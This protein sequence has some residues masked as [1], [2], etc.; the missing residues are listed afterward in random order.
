M[1]RTLGQQFAPYTIPEG[2]KIEISHLNDPVGHGAAL[3]MYIHALPHLFLP[4]Q[5][6]AI[7]I[8]LHQHIGNDRGGGA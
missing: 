8:F 7:C 2:A 3:Q 4:V 5:G 6:H 1:N